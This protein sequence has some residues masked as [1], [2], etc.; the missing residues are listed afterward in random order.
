[1]LAATTD[2]S[3]DKRLL[4]AEECDHVA[5][6][7]AL[8]LP[9]ETD[10]IETKRSVFT[11][12]PTE[13]MLSGRPEAVIRAIRILEDLPQDVVD[14]MAE[15]TSRIPQRYVGEIEEEIV[16]RDMSYSAPRAEKISQR[17][18]RPAIY[19]EPS[20]LPIGL[21]DVGVPK[22]ISAG[23]AWWCREFFT[24]YQM[25]GVGRAPAFELRVLNAEP[26]R[27]ILVRIIQ[28]YC[29][30]N[31]LDP[32]TLAAQVA[33]AADAG[34]KALK[35]LEGLAYQAKSTEPQ[36]KSLD[37][38]NAEQRTV[39]REAL[40]SPA[41]WLGL[42]A[43]MVSRSATDDELS[44]MLVADIATMDP[45]GQ[46]WAVFAACHLATD[47]IGVAERLTGAE[48]GARSAAAEYLNKFGGKS[49]AVV[50]LNRRFLDDEDLRV[51]LAAG[52]Q[53]PADAV[54]TVWTCWSC[55]HVNEIAAEECTNCARG[56]RPDA[57]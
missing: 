24:L 35:H 38:I 4:S 7:L 1:M 26:G 52:Y 47:P 57:G 40:K 13:P 44:A 51:Q 43:F 16:R 19:D 50:A 10:L 18:P 20:A 23:A 5:G 39:L 45:R 33:H 3:Y 11:F 27:S 56:S 32:D 9:P 30:V 8:P 55:L 6:L 37:T 2:A 12:R 42:L 31:H 41:G 49:E 46:R 34:Q 25:L 53:G 48:V 36:T 21:I 28:I 54:A 17:W 14:A 29:A 22:T 15:F